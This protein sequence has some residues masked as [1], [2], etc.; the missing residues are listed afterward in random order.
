M[1][2]FKSILF[3]PFNMKRSSKESSEVEVTDKKKRQKL[4][5]K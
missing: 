4:N 1:Y 3:I 5:I 2:N